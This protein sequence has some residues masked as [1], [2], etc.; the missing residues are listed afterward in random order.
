MEDLPYIVLYHSLMFH[1]L[2]FFISTV[3]IKKKKPSLGA[4]SHVFVSPLAQVPETRVLYNTHLLTL[5]TP[6]F[7]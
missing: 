3:Y 4:V 7:H 6:S 1:C 2:Y 5:D